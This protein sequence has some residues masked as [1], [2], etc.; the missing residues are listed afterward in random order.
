MISAHCIPVTSHWLVDLISP[1]ASGAVDYAYGRQ[2][3]R[4]GTSNISEMHLFEDLYPA[5][6]VIK[7]AYRYCNNANSAICRNIWETNKFDEQITGREDLKLAKHVIETGGVVSY[8]PEAQVE[9]IHEE[10][11][12]QIK[13][14]S[15]REAIAEWEIDKTVYNENKLSIGKFGLKI[16]SDITK[17][18]R[19]R[20]QIIIQ[21]FKFRTA[22]FWGRY[23]IHLRNKKW[24][25]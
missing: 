20:I 15:K 1:I 23:V 25:V 13:K 11:W 9:H 2:I 5:K 8:V 7:Y 18:K 12:K 24:F 4:N 19:Y 21:I 6:S 17:L 16:F 22:E 10:S 3:G 14:R